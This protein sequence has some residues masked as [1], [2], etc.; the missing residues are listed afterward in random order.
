MYMQAHKHITSRGAPP[1][2]ILCALRGYRSVF[3]HDN[4]HVDGCPGEALSSN[5]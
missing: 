5:V 2:D 1:E 3:L 4:L